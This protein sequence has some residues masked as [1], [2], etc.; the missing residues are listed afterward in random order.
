MTSDR[1]CTLLNVSMH[2]ILRV[3][4]GS[5]K[6]PI[7]LNNLLAVRLNVLTKIHVY[8]I[9]ICIIMTSKWTTNT[10]AVF[11]KTYTSTKRIFC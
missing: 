6:L 1:M 9:Y 3:L 10:T 2:F 4:T 8:Y 5:V 7:L 11:S